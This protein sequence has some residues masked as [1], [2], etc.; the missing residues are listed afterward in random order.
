MVSSVVDDFF[1][2]SLWLFVWPLQGTAQISTVS[3]EKRGSVN[4][5]RLSVY[6]DDREGRLQMKAS[7]SILS[8]EQKKNILHA[9]SGRTCYK[10]AY[11]R[12]SLLFD[13]DPKCKEM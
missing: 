2:V 9:R 13:L 3:T 1:L 8:K 4:L 10:W 6:S 11:R 7:I 12:T 5:R